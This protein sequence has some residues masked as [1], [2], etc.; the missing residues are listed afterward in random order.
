MFD[1]EKVIITG[2]T[3]GIGLDLARRL[4]HSGAQCLLIGRDA[5]KGT[6]AAQSLTGARFLQTDLANSS[7]VQKLTEQLERDHPGTRYLVNNAGIFVP[8]PFVDA[9]ERDYDSYHDINRGTYFLTQS[10]VKQML[11]RKLSGSIVNVGSMWGQQAVKA[12]PSSAYSMAKAGLHALTQH[13]AMELGEHNIRVNAVAPAVVA[14]PVY[15][16]FIPQDQ[17]VEALNGFTGIH[18]LG[19]I[20]TPSDVASAI[21]FLLSEQSSWITGTLLNVDGGVMAGRT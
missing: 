9:S 3:S 12:T 6:A 20:G 7:E 4:S 19:R 14:T 15:N 18:P 11:E 10:M 13:L 2:G 8:L 16:A 17:V 1:N 5:A 21:E